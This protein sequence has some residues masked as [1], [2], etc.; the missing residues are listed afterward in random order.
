M[1]LS[2]GSTVED[3]IVSGRRVIVGSSYKSK[4]DPHN[5]AQVFFLDLEKGPRE[6]V[7]LLVLFDCCYSTIGR[8]ADIPISRVQGVLQPI[9]E[10]PHAKGVCDVSSATIYPVTPS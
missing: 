5:K 1:E 3:L 4:E 2:K 10:L 6:W 7:S 8:Q 9:P